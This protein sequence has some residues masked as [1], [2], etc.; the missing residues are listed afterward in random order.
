MKPAPRLTGIARFLP[1]DFSE[2]RVEDVSRDENFPRPKRR[3]HTARRL[4][5]PGDRLALTVQKCRQ[6]SGL[7]FTRLAE[8]SGIDVAHLWRIEQG[9]HQNVSREILILLSIALIVDS[10]AVDHIVN[11]ANEILDAAGFKLL[12]ASCSASQHHASPQAD[13]AQDGKNIIE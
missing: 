12:R 6:V 11:V 10:T 7:S 13:L 9:E 1:T 3:P 2:R 4:E 8:R 5:L